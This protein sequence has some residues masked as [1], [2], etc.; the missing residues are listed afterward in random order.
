MDFVD[1]TILRIADETSRGA[2]FDSE[3]LSQLLSA[4]HDVAGTGIDAPFALAFDEISFVHDD[5]PRVELGG[6]WMTLGHNERT[7]LAIQAAGIG[8]PI[9]RIDLLAAGTITASARSGGAP[10]TS[11]EF[12]EPL[13][14]SGTTATGT[15][16]VG[17]GD[18]PDASARQRRFPLAA[19]LLVR[20]APLSLAGLLDETRRLRPHLHRL[21]FG[22]ANTLAAA[23]ASP[24]MRRSPIVAWVLPATLFDDVAWPGATAAQRRSWAGAWLA[25]ERIGLIVPPT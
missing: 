12:T 22:S 21:G 3:S 9:P 4:S 5:E 18:G 1:A 2:V 14:P 8:A 6:S 20:D 16:R 19:A 13:T 10:I 15:M 7:E 24:R 23:A 11:A 25:R 17:F